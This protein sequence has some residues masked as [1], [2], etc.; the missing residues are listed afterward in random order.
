MKRITLCHSCWGCSEVGTCML[1]LEFRVVSIFLDSILWYLPAV[2]RIL[3]FAS[4]TVPCLETDLKKVDRKSC[5]L[6]IGNSLNNNHN[7]VMINYD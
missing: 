5:R 3:P 7:R 1:L 6:R 2:L 4:V